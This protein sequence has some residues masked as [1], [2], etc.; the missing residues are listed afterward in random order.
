MKA[1]ALN[2]TD[3]QAQLELVPNWQYDTNSIVREYIFNDF[4][5]AFGFM[6]QVAMLAERANHHPEW[7]NV[8][9]RVNIKLTTHDCAGLSQLDFALAHEIDQ[10]GKTGAR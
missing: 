9:K 2:E 6:S 1:I 10:I 5:E 8:Y 3:I 4:V 7:S